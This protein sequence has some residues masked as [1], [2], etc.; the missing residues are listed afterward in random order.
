ML[1]MNP[2]HRPS[3]SDV[4]IELQAITLQEKIYP[5]NELFDTLRG[6]IEGKIDND[7]AIVFIEYARYKSWKETCGIMP[8]APQN[9]PIGLR[10]LEFDACV[11][12]LSRYQG[13]LEEILDRLQDADHSHLFLPLRYINIRLEQLFLP[14]MQRESQKRLV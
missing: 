5:I 10:E 13:T 9:A 7:E 8:D 2:D 12:I 11:G 6:E 4:T 3:A 14:E 1:Q